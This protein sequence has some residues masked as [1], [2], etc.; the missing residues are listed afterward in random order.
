MFLLSEALPNW[1]WKEVQT[2][3]CGL[4]KDKGDSS[5][6][7]WW[8]QKFIAQGSEEGLCWSDNRDFKC[9]LMIHNRPKS[10]TINSQPGFKPQHQMYSFW[11]RIHWFPAPLFLCISLSLQAYETVVN[12]K[13]M[14]KYLILRK[15]QLVGCFLWPGNSSIKQWE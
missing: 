8:L 5:A 14:Y 3:N 6:K 7:F 4:L 2:R 1:Q 9:L 13:A 10:N 15:I 12:T 11:I